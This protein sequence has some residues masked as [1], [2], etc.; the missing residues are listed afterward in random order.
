[1]EFKPWN[2]LTRTFKQDPKTSGNTKHHGGTVGWVTRV[3]FF[4]REPFGNGDPEQHV[5]GVSE[6]RTK[7]A[8]GVALSA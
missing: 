6:T 5:T 7:T 4:S 8:G 1:M 2:V 3:R